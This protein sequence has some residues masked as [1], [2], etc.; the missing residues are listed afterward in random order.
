MKRFL[1]AAAVAAGLGGAIAAPAFA[2]DMATPYPDRP[3]PG[4]DRPESMEHMDRPDGDWSLGRREAWLEARIDRG[5]ERGRLSGNEEQRGRAELESI[6]T[7]EAKLRDRDGGRL[8]PEDRTYVANR[9]DGLYR[10]LRWQGDNPPPP[11]SDH[12]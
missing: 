4:A 9:I 12:F 11:W 5:S 1:I 7:E 6:R 2:Q 10:T 3:P 8:S